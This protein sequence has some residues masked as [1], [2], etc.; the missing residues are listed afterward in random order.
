MATRRSVFPHL[1]R[2]S[3]GFASSGTVTGAV[4]TTGTERAPV[5]ALYLLFQRKD[6][7]HELP[8][9]LDHVPQERSWSRRRT[10]LKVVQWTTTNDD[11]QTLERN[12]P[13]MPQ[14]QQ[15]ALC[16]LQPP[17][18]HLEQTALQCSDIY[19]YMSI[20]NHIHTTYTQHIRLVQSKP[21]HLGI[22]SHASC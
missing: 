2:P 22:L 13:A 6:F 16:Q 3:L 15:T 7:Q 9:S 21:Q 5:K 14:G 4:L 11:P 17:K 19:T 8:T 20:Q 18:Q 10:K 12:L 1:S